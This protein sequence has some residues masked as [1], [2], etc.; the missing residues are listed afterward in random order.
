[1]LS[2]QEIQQFRSQLMKQIEE[3]PADQSDAMR[4]QVESMD[5]QQFEEFLIKNKMIQQGRECVF[6]SIVKRDIESFII[7]ENNDVVIVLELNPVSRGHAL[8]IPKKHLGE[9][10]MI[11]DSILAVAKLVS[12]FLKSKLKA[13]RVDWLIN[14]RAE[15]VV[16][17]LIPVYDKEFDFQRGKADKNELMKLSKELSFEFETEK[18]ED[19]EEIEYEM[20]RR[21]P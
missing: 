18:K 5:D 12:A 16:F 13:K 11:S 3:L 15:H 14:S 17:N 19:E 6:C 21:R 10:E 9:I 8:I 4:M 2:K 1:M 7:A 20:P